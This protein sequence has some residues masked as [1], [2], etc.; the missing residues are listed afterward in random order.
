[1]FDFPPSLINGYNYFYNNIFIPQKSYY[2]KLA[3]KGQKTQILVIAC[4]D[5]RAAPETIFN[6]YLGE[7]FVIRNI[8]N[9]IP[10]F[11]PDSQYHGTSSALEFGVQKL[12]VKHIVVLGH[13]RC[14]GVAA[15]ADP[16][17]S[18]LTESDFIGSWIKLLEPA[19]EQVK[20]LENINEEQKR[21][22]LEYASV[23]CSL[24]NLRTFPWILE[25]EQKQELK[26]HGAWFD[27]ENGQLWIM[28]KES[29]EFF[30]LCV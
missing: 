30:C 25:K 8:A 1:M 14:S 12:K 10:P 21:R 4:C 26:L 28:E 22:L 2:K 7:I 3:K 19:V 27:I 24:D 13:S 17:L 29:K 11:Q 16:D 6:S 15:S 23:R 5:S 18:P 9:Q 20:S